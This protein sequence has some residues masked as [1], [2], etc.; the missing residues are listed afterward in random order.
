MLCE[1]SLF[2][3]VLINKLFAGK[4]DW[5]QQSQAP[6]HDINGTSWWRLALSSCCV[7]IHNSSDLTMRQMIIPQFSSFYYAQRDNNHPQGFHMRF[8]PLGVCNKFI[9]VTNLFLKPKRAIYFSLSMS[10]WNWRN[11]L[12]VWICMFLSETCWGG[13]AIIIPS[14]A[15]GLTHICSVRI[16]F[17]T[18]LMFL[19]EARVLTWKPKPGSL[20]PVHVLYVI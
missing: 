11:N 13:C 4:M 2:I 16:F 19:T 8:P 12:S 15:N 17:W 1:F 3:S 14:G 18:S 10:S 20:H 7:V 9:K 5:M 6:L